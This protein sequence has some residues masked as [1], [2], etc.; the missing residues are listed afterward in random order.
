[1]TKTDTARTEDKWYRLKAYQYVDDYVMEAC[2][3]EGSAHF[4]TAVAN[5]E[6][7]LRKAGD[8]GAATQ[9]AEDLALVEGLYAK[10]PAYD[11][12]DAIAALQAQVK[13]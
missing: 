1:M 2:R 12:E 5:V 11:I 6:R 8:H 4:K 9:Q 7:L 13:P 3:N 10:G